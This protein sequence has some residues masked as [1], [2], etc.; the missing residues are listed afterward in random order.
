M[1]FFFSVPHALEVE[2]DKKKIKYNLKNRFSHVSLSFLP[3]FIPM[4][5]PQSAGT[6]SEAQ[7]LVKLRGDIRSVG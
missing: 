5:L 3:L 2:Q 4:H 6:L 7:I 1:W